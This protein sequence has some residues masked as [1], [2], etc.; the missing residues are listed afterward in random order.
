MKLRVLLADDHAMLR[1]ALRLVLD[2]SPD[3]E[4]VAEAAN[5]RDVLGAFDE[6]RPDVVCMDV[7]MPG[8]DGVAATRQLL[9]SHP[10]VKI[11]GLSCHVD[12]QRVAEMIN[13]GALGYVVKMDAAAELLPAIR[14]VSLNQSY[15]SAE[16]NISD[17]SALALA[18]PA[19]SATDGSKQSS[20]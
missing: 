19:T 11:I 13:A 2:K 16:L 1:K 15:F 4:V 20:H 5:G 3:V 6:S 9:A 17:A 12:L 8:L 14:K 18:M 7:R 10:E